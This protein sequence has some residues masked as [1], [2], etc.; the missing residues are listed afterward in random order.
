MSWHSVVI[1][2]CLLLSAFAVY[3]EYVR[4][5][6]AH[7]LWRIVAVLLAVTALAGVIWPITY[8]A[9]VTQTPGAGKILLTEGFNADSL[10]KNDSIYTLDKSVHQQYPKAK[11]LDDLQAL[12]NDSA[13]ITP[14]HILGY[15][16][17]A[18]ELEQLSGRQVVFHPSPV[19]DG[20]TAVNWTEK[21]KTG[22]QFNVQGTYQ[23]TSAKACA[24]VLKGLNTTLDSVTIPARSNAPFSLKSIPKNSGRV[25]YSLIVLNGK[26][27]LK[28]ES[29][30][31]IIEKNQALKVLLLSSSPDFES[32][33]L[34]TWLGGNGYGMASR[35]VISKGKFGQEYLNMD[36]PDLSH[37]TATLLSKFD[38]VVGDLS[39]LK[40]LSPPESSALQQEISQKGLGLIIRAD[41]ADKK[42]SWLQS[43]FP[44]SYQ[45]GKQQT[46][47]ALNIRGV[48]KTAKLNI[49]PVDIIPQSNTQALITDEHGHTHAG[50][51]LS[52]AGKLIFTTI[53]HT[54]S[55]MLA[56]NQTDYTALWSLLIETAARKSPVTENWSVASSLPVTNQPV[57]LVLESGLPAGDIKVNQS[58]VYPSQNPAVPFQQSVTY[59]PAAYG[60]QQVTRPNGSPYWWYAWKK[61]EWLSL[62]AVKKLTLTSQYVKDNPAIATV[63]KQIQQ[64]THASVPKIYF[65]ILFLMA[66]TFLWAE[67]KFFS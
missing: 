18:D 17:D 9:T 4:E 43:S 31:V 37:I 2:I 49:D 42:P 53:N 61:N 54:Y 58:V 20:F 24:L 6:K 57:A 56:G 26:D 10:N 14:V 52:G 13:H 35:S 21:V 41:S 50:L 16:L 36:Q 29:L 46:P 51:T 45:A 11:L 47:M 15:G 67:S 62:K 33:F 55:W 59:W 65:Y 3:R 44:I 66:A 5:N 23:N 63:T 38:I 1:W 64:K 48:G 8:S 39:A 34:K 25:V 19:P 60:W 7:L 22:R 30:P 32:K 40:S 28:Q 27:T 12:F